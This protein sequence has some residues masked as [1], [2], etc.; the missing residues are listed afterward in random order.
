MKHNYEYPIKLER[1]L[2]HLKISRNLCKTQCIKN[3]LQL[4]RCWRLTPVV[5]EKS[6]QNCYSVFNIAILL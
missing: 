6:A 4:I 1:Y 5:S 3:I 2:F